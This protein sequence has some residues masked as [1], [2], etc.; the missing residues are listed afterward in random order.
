M[1]NTGPD[2]NVADT[3]LSIMQGALHKRDGTGEVLEREDKDL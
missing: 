2:L 3:F 1:H